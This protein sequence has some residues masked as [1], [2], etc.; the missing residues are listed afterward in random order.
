[1][2]VVDEEVNVLEHF[3]WAEAGIRALF[4]GDTAL[5]FKIEVFLGDADDAEGKDPALGKLCVVEDQ[6]G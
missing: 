1:M 4:R 3:G 2:G 5:L 6:N